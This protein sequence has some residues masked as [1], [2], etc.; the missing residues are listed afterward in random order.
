M[1]NPIVPTAAEALALAWRYA[2][3]VTLGESALRRAEVLLGIATEIRQE[4]Q[5]RAV[6]AR[7]QSIDRARAAYKLAAAGIPMPESYNVKPETFGQT[8]GG[9]PAYAG[10]TAVDRTARIIREAGYVERPTWESAVTRPIEVEGYTGTGLDKTQ[11]IETLWTVGDKA[12]CR[13]CHTPIEL[14]PVAVEVEGEPPAV[15]RHKYSGQAT[16]AV[17]TMSGEQ[18][19]EATHTFAEPESRG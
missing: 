1:T 17:A 7:R 16:C 9:E 6:E 2:S 10:E 14:C 4:R 12:Q 8:Y 19:A 5:F 18:G 15:W 13:H 3:D 11:R